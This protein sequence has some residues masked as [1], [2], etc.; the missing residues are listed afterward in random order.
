VRKG[1]GDVR[2]SFVVYGLLY[3]MVE[4][5]GAQ[6]EQIGWPSL[7]IPCGLSA[8]HPQN[9]WGRRAHSARFFASGSARISARSAD[10]STMAFPAP[11]ARRSWS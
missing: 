7:T 10:T 3:I 5:V 4:L 11:R 2:I 9:N 8:C 6:L 1:G